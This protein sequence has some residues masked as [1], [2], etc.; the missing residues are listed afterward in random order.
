MVYFGRGYVHHKI[1]SAHRNRFLKV[2]T[3]VRERKTFFR[4]SRL[5]RTGS[6]VNPSRQFDIGM[7]IQIAGP[8]LSHAAGPY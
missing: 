4:G 1:R 3:V 5:G 6:H 7:I 2:G 8:T